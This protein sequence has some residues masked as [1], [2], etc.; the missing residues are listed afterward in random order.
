M[1]TLLMLFA[2]FLL[3]SQSFAEAPRKETSDL[4][5]IVEAMTQAY[6][7]SFTKDLALKKI[8]AYAA[9]AFSGYVSGSLA[10]GLSILALIGSVQDYEKARSEGQMY[11]AMSHAFANAMSLYAP[12]IGA[13]LQL[14]VLSQDLGAAV[15]SKGFQLGQARVLA[16]ISEA[17]RQ[18]VDLATKEFNSEKSDF[19]EGLARLSALEELGAAAWKQTKRFCGDDGYDYLTPQECYVAVTASQRI[20]VKKL[21]TLKWLVNFNGRF[22]STAS[23]I[24]EE[25]YKKTLALIERSQKSLRDFEFNINAV[26]SQ[27]ST[28]LLESTRDNVR[29]E[30]LARTCEVELLTR[31]TRIL[32]YKKRMI[33]SPDEQSWINEVLEQEVLDIH[34]V[35]EGMCTPVFHQLSPDLRDIYVKIR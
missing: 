20:A 9:D 27:L 14:G 26:I 23:V 8:D 21:A 28:K 11:S 13:L 19:N 35:A 5:A 22:F 10:K 24:G 29:R 7:E 32:R 31:L 17:Q 2:S 1:K 34:A 15:V 3:T 30:R 4:E 6:L 16:E 25:N 12:P 18:T 33:Q